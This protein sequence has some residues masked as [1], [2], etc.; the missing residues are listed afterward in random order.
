MWLS[1]TER[2]KYS[3][4]EADSRPTLDG[5]IQTIEPRCEIT[6]TLWIF[7]PLETPLIYKTTAAEATGLLWRLRYSFSHGFLKCVHANILRYSRLLEKLR[8]I[9]GS[10]SVVFNS[11]SIEISGIRSNTSIRIKWEPPPNADQWTI[12]AGCPMELNLSGFNACSLFVNDAVGW[13]RNRIVQQSEFNGFR[14]LK[15]TPPR[16]VHGS[17]TRARVSGRAWHPGKVSGA[18]SGR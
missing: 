9:P 13:C 2:T 14:S 5:I 15:R 3:I 12:Q 11:I 10:N 8:R 17:R 16:G 18:D 4:T 7:R 6:L 1:N